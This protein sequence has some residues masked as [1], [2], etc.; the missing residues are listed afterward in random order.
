MGGKAASPR[1]VKLDTAEIEYH[2]RH[3]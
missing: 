3:S 2:P 1:V